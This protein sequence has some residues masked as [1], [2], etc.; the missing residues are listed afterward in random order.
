MPKTLKKPV[1]SRCVFTDHE[2]RS[3]LRQKRKLGS[4][5]NELIFSYTKK[6]NNVS[7]TFLTDDALLEMNI[8][9]L[10]H[11]TYTDI[12]TFD[13]SDDVANTILGDIYISA[14]R[15]RENAKNLA[16]TFQ[17]ELLR[18]I[19]HGALH[20]SGYGDKTKKDKE[21]M[22]GLESSWMDAYKSKTFIEVAASKR[23]GSP[24]FEERS[25]G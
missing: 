7:Y 2:I 22:R 12:I 15:V 18:V 17:D 5:I 24:L 19:L 21:V 14:D 10:N 23:L 13:L 3:G 16:V 9:F 4:F 1:N 11:D 25:R 8:E 20:L 6:E